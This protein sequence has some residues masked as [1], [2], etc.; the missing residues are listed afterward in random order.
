MASTAGFIEWN[1]QS[2]IPVIS[3]DRSHKMLLVLRSSWVGTRRRC[4]ASK[5][6][7]NDR[8]YSWRLF[9]PCNASLRSA[10]SW[11]VTEMISDFLAKSHPK[12]CVMSEKGASGWL[13]MVGP[14][15]GPINTVGSC[16]DCE[17]A[18]GLWATTLPIFPGVHTRN[19]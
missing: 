4:V 16:K 14:R 12:Y 9:K 5:V 13:S 3:P 8:V 15:H 18:A 10:G 17:V 2:M 7:H 1:S 11:G 6:R 19:I